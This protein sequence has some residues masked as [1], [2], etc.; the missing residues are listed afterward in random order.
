MVIRGMY[1]TK[2][3]ECIS[4][5]QI[6]LCWLILLRCCLTGGTGDSGIGADYALMSVLTA[7]LPGRA[8][9]CWSI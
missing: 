7:R 5:R 8:A 9:C 2:S 6:G 3:A 4:T 1:W